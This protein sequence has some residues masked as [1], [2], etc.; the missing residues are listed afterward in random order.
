MHLLLVLSGLLLS[1]SFLLSFRLFLAA[2][3]SGVIECM[4][5]AYFSAPAR[6]SSFAQFSFS[7]LAA[8]CSG[9]EPCLSH[10]LCLVPSLSRSSKHISC[11][12]SAAK[13]TVASLSYMS[14]SPCPRR[15][16]AT[17]QHSWCSRPHLRSIETC[18]LYPHSRPHPATNP[19]T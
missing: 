2:N 1:S 9:S 14:S 8:R 13:C 11:P 6:S 10:V 5:F 7:Y 19:C 16:A 3:S 15:R 17:A 12:F 18:Y 4:S